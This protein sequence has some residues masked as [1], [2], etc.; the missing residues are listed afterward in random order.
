MTLRKCLFLQ[1][2]DSNS[3]KQVIMSLARDILKGSRVV[4]CVP[5]MWILEP[6]GWLALTVHLI[7]VYLS[8]FPHHYCVEG[9]CILNWLFGAQHECSGQPLSF[10]VLLNTEKEKTV[11]TVTRKQFL[12][13]SV[14]ILYKETLQWN[15][16]NCETPKSLVSL[17]PSSLSSLTLVI[18]RIHK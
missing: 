15:L 17:L 2:S 3:Y 8:W 4:A 5:L 1:L 7:K 18:H 16:L 6:R 13:C 9:V 14:D 11:W 10:Q 12:R